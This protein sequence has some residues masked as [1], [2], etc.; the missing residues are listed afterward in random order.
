MN[1]PKIVGESNLVICVHSV[2]A[3][4]GVDYGKFVTV[5]TRLINTSF[6]RYRGSRIGRR[7]LCTCINM[8]TSTTPDRLESV[9][10]GAKLCAVWRLDLLR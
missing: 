4:A 5:H 8:Y 2:E 9:T 7:L 1:S 10:G 6:L 3:S